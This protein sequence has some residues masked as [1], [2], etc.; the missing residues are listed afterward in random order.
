MVKHPATGDTNFL[1]NIVQCQIKCQT[2]DIEYGVYGQYFTTCIPNDI[3]VSESIYVPSDT[4]ASLK[5]IRDEGHDSFKY[6]IG[7]CRVICLTGAAYYF[8]RLPLGT[9]RY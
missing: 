3:R 4:V 8:Y 9:P 1:S 2:Y 5:V 7:N 6:A